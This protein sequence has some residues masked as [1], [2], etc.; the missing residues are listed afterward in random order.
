MPSIAV[1]PDQLNTS[2]NQLITERR[3]VVIKGVQN[4]KFELNIN[5]VLSVKGDIRIIIRC[6]TP[7]V[8]TKWY[9]YSNIIMIS[10]ILESRDTSYIDDFFVFQIIQL[11]YNVLISSD[12]NI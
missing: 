7:T 3:P 5:S 11:L 8:T 2:E 9:T 4:Q 1:Y 6:L 12:N 10:G